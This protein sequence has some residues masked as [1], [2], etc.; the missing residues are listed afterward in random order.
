M[1][2]CNT[3]LL[4]FQHETIDEMSD[5]LKNTVFRGIEKRSS[6]PEAAPKYNAFYCFKDSIAL[7]TSAGF[8]EPTQT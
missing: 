5:E 4:I 1:F 7:Q 2:F 8:F 6:R 3:P